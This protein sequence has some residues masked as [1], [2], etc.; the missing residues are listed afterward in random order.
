MRQL[1]QRGSKFGMLGMW[2]VGTPHM[3]LKVFQLENIMK[4]AVPRL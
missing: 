1:E 2:A 4:W 3:K